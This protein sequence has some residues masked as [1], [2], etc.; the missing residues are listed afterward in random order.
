[1]TLPPEP[2]IDSFRRRLALWLLLKYALAGLTL[3]AFLWG[4]AVLA[5]RGALGVERLDLLWG[6]AGA[7]GPGVTYFRGSYMQA[8]AAVFDEPRLAFSADE[9]RAYRLT[10]R[11]VRYEWKQGPEMAIAGVQ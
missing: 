3:F 5:L 1:M 7:T 10:T 11:E 8:L 2:G 6:L 9:M 4:T